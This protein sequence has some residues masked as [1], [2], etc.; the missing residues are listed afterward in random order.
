MELRIGLLLCLVGFNLHDSREKKREARMK[1][2]QP[3]Q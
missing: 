1:K 3:P 2:F